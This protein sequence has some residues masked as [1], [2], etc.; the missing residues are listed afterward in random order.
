MIVLD[1]TTE[2]GFHAIRL[3]DWLR[4]FSSREPTVIPDVKDFLPTMG[5]PAVDDE[6][7]APRWLPEVLTVLET[8]G[9]VELLRVSGS[10]LGYGIRLTGTGLRDVHERERRRKCTVLRRQASRA[11]ILNWLG[12]LSAD[13]DYHPEIQVI[14]DSPWGTYE[15]LFLTRED[16]INALEYLV[17]RG[18]VDLNPL[19]LTR[20]G[21]DCV[22]KHAGAVHTYEDTTRRTTMN[23]FNNFYGA[24]NPQINQ[25][26]DSVQQIQMTAGLPVD[27]MLQVARALQRSSG[28]LGLSE[29]ERS[30]LVQTAADLEG[31]AG[32]ANPDETEVR[33]LLGR[34]VNLLNRPGTTELA[35]TMVATIG[36]LAG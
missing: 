28:L 23:T 16:L 13:L 24:G 12:E 7:V 8:D 30:A 22:E 29:A 1:S 36:Q 18:L 26:G 2:I 34:L 5:K 33:G 35:T 17:D 14:R 27:Q 15:G 25:G 20:E 19:R 6:D 21:V 10:Y 32:R 31:A 4:S 9:H 3:L 11:N